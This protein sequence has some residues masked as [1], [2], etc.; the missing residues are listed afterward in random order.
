M[1]RHEALV[2]D[3]VVVASCAVEIVER[4]AAKNLHPERFEVA[5]A[6]RDLRDGGRLFAR[7]RLPAV[8][9]QQPRE[10][11]AE[12]HVGRDGRRLNASNTREA[13]V[14]ALEE[15]AALLPRRVLLVRQREAHGEQVPGL[16]AHVHAIHVH[17]APHHEACAGEQDERERELR[18]DEH[19]CPASCAHPTASRPAAFLQHLVEIGLRHVQR[20]SEAEH[21]ARA[22]THGGEKGEDLCVHRERNPVRLSDI[23]RGRVE[24][25]DA[26][27]RQRQ[28]QQ[29][30]KNR[31]Q[32]ALH[33]QLPDDAPA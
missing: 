11:A 2:D 31:Q 29:A 22:E 9:G 15:R 30:A 25:T 5:R 27:I 12:R 6:N 13:L 24:E 10:A 19:A 14:E 16:H 18:H 33:E 26:D 1:H 7:R 21:D 20:G 32:Q 8:H 28:P 17:E 4:P 23:L 3:G